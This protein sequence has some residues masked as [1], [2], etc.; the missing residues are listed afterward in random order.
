MNSENA[1]DLG[2]EA[3]LFHNILPFERPEGS[4]QISSS[5]DCRSLSCQPSIDTVHCVEVR[6]YCIGSLTETSEWTYH[7]YTQSPLNMTCICSI[8]SGSSAF[9]IVDCKELYLA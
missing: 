9:E 6:N 7:H 2:L 8:Q 1:S 4:S 3:K 5:Y